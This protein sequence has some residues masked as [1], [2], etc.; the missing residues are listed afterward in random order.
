VIRRGCR[1]M[2]QPGL[3]IFR[4]FACGSDETTGDCVGM[5]SE[6]SG[7]AHTVPAK[8]EASNCPTSFIGFRRGDRRVSLSG[9]AA[10]TERQRVFRHG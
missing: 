7:N 9:E 6:L 8:L 1:R 5:G 10:G 3:T 2:S 4:R